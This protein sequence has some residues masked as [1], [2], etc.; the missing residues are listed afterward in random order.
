MSAFSRWAYRTKKTSSWY[1]S[2]NNELKMLTRK[3]LKSE[4]CRLSQG[5]QWSIIFR[6]VLLCL[7]LISV[8]DHM[9]VEFSEL[10]ALQKEGADYGKTI[11]DVFQYCV[12]HFLIACNDLA[13]T[14]KKLSGRECQL[15]IF[16][17]ECICH[18]IE[19]R[20]NMRNDELNS[21]IHNVCDALRDTPP[22]LN[23]RVFLHL[24]GH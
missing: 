20:G 2:I 22:H 15:L 5:S 19:H 7:V 6:V 1:I 8:T 18:K 4:G 24:F 23:W 17:L 10:A 16:L 14:W 13:D 21:L 11:P 9:L 3:S 12:R